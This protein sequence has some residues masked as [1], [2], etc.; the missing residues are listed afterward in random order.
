MK[1]Y[2]AAYKK[3]LP[4]VIAI[5]T[6]PVGLHLLDSGK[7]EQPKKFAAYKKMQKRIV[8]I[9]PLNKTSITPKW[10][11]SG[12]VTP[13]ELV[14]L[15]AQVSGEIDA[16]NINSKPGSLLPKGEWLVQIDKTDYELLLRS[17]KADLVQA[18]TS[19]ALEQADQI[20]A[21]E[22]L[23]LIDDEQQSL[24]ETALILREPQLRSAQAKVDNAKINLEKAE[25]ALARTKIIMPFAG[26]VVSRSIGRGSRVGQ[27]SKLFEIVNVE[28]F[29]IEVKVPRS[30]LAILDTNQPA[31]LTQPKLWGEGVSRQAKF[32]SVL[33]ELDSR[34]RQVK[35]LFAIDNPLA[36]LNSN[37]MSK[38]PAIFINDFINVELQGQALN[39]VWQIQSN[40]LQPDN[41]VWVV[42][43]QSTLQKRSVNIHFKGRQFVY[44][45]ADF[46]EGDKLVAEKPGIASIGLNVIIRGA[47]KKRK[48]DDDE[49]S[50]SQLA[51]SQRKRDKKVN[52][53]SRGSN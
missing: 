18:Q 17:E 42:D 32:I 2:F 16:V 52:R 3:W 14:N 20:L 25:L 13:S 5:I 24:M 11:S 1:N 23:S 30:F 44:V 8:K 41:T 21:K 6:I 50:V 12:V 39:D 35:L 15:V 38:A 19:L 9:T 27:N 48:L 7:I 26:K 49:P 40:R 51:A 36:A 46:K 43:E 47:N 31:T 33:P 28:Q 29:W 37:N 10:Q 45:T 53:E 22:E 4:A 34:D